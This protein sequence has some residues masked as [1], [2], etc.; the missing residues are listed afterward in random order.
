MGTSLDWFKS[1]LYNRSQFVNF[2]KTK[3]NISSL[4]CSIPQGSTLG[5]ILFNI[6]INDIVNAT[7]NLNCVLFADDSCFYYS[8]NDINTL[9]EI[10]NTDLLQVNSWLNSNKVTLNLDK[11]HFI[12]FNRKLTLPVNIPQ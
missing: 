2:N 7:K 3:S 10:V 9:I 6:F 12:I 11:S 4:N 5:P 8:H 1:Y